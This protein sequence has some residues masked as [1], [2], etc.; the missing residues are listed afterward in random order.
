MKKEKYYIHIP[1]QEIWDR[2]L[3]KIR[4]ERNYYNSFNCYNGDCCVA[5]NDG[6]HGSTAYFIGEG[7]VEQSWEQF[8]N[9][10]SS[11]LIFN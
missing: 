1:T 6:S 10:E 9:E 3:R 2:V 11:A 8:L 5:S 7:W 4:K